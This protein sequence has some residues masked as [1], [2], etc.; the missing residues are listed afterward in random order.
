[1]IGAVQVTAA[2]ALVVVGLVVVV[3]FELFCLDDLARTPDVELQLLT[4]TGWLVLI[5]LF[6]PVGGVVYLYRGKA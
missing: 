4:R 3:R 5:L 2:A 1:M 6:V